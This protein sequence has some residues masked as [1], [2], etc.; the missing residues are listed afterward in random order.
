MARSKFFWI[1]FPVLGVIA[2]MEIF[3][4]L[5]SQKVL[6]VESVDISALV[7]SKACIQTALKTVGGGMIEETGIEGMFETPI[8]EEMGRFSIKSSI[9]KDKGVIRVSIAAKQEGVD[10]EKKLFLRSRLDVFA[11]ALTVECSK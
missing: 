1:I 2:L 11:K 4:N 8:A 9:I 10:E 3:T 7:P 6:W 5:T